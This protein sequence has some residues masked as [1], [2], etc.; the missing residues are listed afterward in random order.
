MA[1]DAL[2]FDQLSR[3]NQVDAALLLHDL[4]ANIW[5]TETLQEWAWNPLYYIQLSGSG[6]YGLLARDFAPIEQRLA[7]AASRLEQLPRFLEQ[8]R[9][10]LVP[11]RVPKI[12]AETAVSQN[13]GLGSIIDSMILPDPGYG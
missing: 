6:I 1:L 11:E 9:G 5:S 8:A 10:E 2:D 13:Q 4:E 7:S 12:H 3:A